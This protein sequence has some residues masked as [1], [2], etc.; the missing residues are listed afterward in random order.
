MRRSQIAG[1]IILVIADVIGASA[2]LYTM[3]SKNPT[4]T[5]GLGISTGVPIGGPF[6]MSNHLGERVDQ[7][8]LKD[9]YSLI[10]FGYTFCPDVCP[11]G[12]Q[13]MIIALDMAGSAAEKVTPIFVTVDPKRDGQEEI[14][15]YVE[16][17]HPRMIG[18]RGT[19]AETTAIAKAFRVY[20]APV[21]QKDDDLYY[22][23]DH[24]NF[25]YLMGPD[26]QNIAIFNGDVD[27]QLMAK[28]IRQ[29]VEG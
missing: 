10:Y 20:Y 11:T 17:F 27:P 16:A 26:G 22:L 7:S 19:E 2:V 5:G 12:L 21:D 23:M 24:S 29:A 9:G 13:D 6:Q 8:V 3:N 18:L 14:A 15:A 4:V 25:I 28:G 1:I